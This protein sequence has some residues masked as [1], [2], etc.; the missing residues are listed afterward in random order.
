MDGLYLVIVFL[1]V[2]L[3]MQLVVLPKLGVP[4]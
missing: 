1:G 2:W 4:T 3:L